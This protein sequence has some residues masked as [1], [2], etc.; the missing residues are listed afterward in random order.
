MHDMRRT[1]RTIGAATPV[2]CCAGG[3]VSCCAGGPVSCCAGGPTATRA[4]AD[5]TR[6]IPDEADPT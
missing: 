4:A 6:S 1:V 2:S 5:W 3:P